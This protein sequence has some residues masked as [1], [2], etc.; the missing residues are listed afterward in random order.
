MSRH[1]TK[2]NQTKQKSP[3]CH[4]KIFKIISQYRQANLTITYH[5]ISKT[6]EGGG[7]VQGELTIPSAVE[8]VEKTEFSDIAGGAYSK[9]RLT[10]S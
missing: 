3:G 1:F 4:E 8:D 7:G 10:I 6:Y 2:P 5:Y 9:N